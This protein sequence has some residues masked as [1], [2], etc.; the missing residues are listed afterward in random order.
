MSLHLTKF[1]LHQ[2]AI[3]ETL[4]SIRILS[5]YKKEDEIKLDG[6]EGCLG[7]PSAILLFSFINTFGNLF[8]GK[9]IAGRQIKNDKSSFQILNSEY[10]KNQNLSTQA[11]DDLYKIYR[12]KLTHNLSLPSN[13]YLCTK[14]NSGNWYEKANNKAGIEIITTVYVFDLLSLCEEALKKITK[15]HEAIYNQSKKI[16][17]L[18]N[19]DAPHVGSIDK[20]NSSGV[21]SMPNGV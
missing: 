16:I 20:F 5:A 17:D 3:N 12:S 4:V 21:T 2:E 9:T 15:E 7:Y 8:D 18:N 14:S 11:L 1:G 13:Y 19:N 6:K 10:F